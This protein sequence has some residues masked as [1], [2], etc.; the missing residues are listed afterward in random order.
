MS[1][2]RPELSQAD[3]SDAEEIVVD[4][5]IL[6]SVAQVRW[7]PA[8]VEGDPVAV[9]RLRRIDEELDDPVQ[10]LSAVR[11]AFGDRV[12]AHLSSRP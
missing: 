12:R 1:L 8:G 5:E 9:A 2:F 3:L 10:F 7:S 4:V 11:I 6:G